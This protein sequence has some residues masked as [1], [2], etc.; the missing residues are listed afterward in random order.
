MVCPMI[1]QVMM[2]GQHMRLIDYQVMEM[3]R[4]LERNGD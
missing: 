3:F 1:S 4:I 2:T